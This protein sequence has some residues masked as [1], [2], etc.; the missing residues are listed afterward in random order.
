MGSYVLGNDFYHPA[1]LARE[2]ATIDLLT[3]GRLELGLG[4]GYYSMDY[5]QTGIPLASPRV[6]VDRLVE[7]VH[8][9]KGLLSGEAVTY[10]GQYYSV[11]DLSV[12]KTSQ[13]PHPPLLLGG[14]SK[15]VL[16]LAA[17][18]AD[19]VSFNI[20]TTPE[21]GFDP[22]SL[23]SEATRQKLDWVLQ[24]GSD[25]VSQM[26]FNILCS[27]AAVTDNPLRKAEEYV[28][29]WNQYGVEYSVEAILASPHIL[30]GSAAQI[31]EK[32]ERNREEF[33]FSYITIFEEDLETFAPVVKLLAGK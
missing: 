3:D 14:G 15:R 27:K 19:I 12:P 5:T 4:T 7:S 18:E 32:L 10:T 30:L 1:V 21:G 31:V 33:G 8:I 16:S 20:R 26:E 28:A 17:R 22:G 11:Q 23:T 6:R 24:A 9:I 25:R 29:E 13:H 2:A